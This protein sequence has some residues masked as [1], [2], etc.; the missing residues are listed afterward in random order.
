MKETVCNIPILVSVVEISG[1]CSLEN[2][3]SKEAAVSST[4]YFMLLL[5]HVFT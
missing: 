1:H 3:K 5:F 2:I 4:N